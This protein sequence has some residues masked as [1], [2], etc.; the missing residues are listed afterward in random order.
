MVKTPPF[1]LSD[2][3]GNILRSSG[4]NVG[5]IPT[6]GMCRNWRFAV[7]LRHD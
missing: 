5:S 7:L 3:T 6:A 1:A 2:V 4:G